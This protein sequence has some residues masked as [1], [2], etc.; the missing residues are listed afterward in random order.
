MTT[1]EDNISSATLCLARQ[2]L[3]KGFI[4][5]RD[6]SEDIF[7]D[8]LVCI[9]SYEFHF[10]GMVVLKFLDISVWQI[11]DYGF[12]VIIDYDTIGYVVCTYKLGQ[13]LID[14]PEGDCLI[15]SRETFSER[16]NL[17]ACFVPLLKNEA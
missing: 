10:K 8:E 15:V 9:N 6:I 4:L 14:V 1:L 17:D 16:A 5:D 2:I 7:N 12:P 13:F 11:I 3:L